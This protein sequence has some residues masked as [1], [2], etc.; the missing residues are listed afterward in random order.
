MRNQIIFKVGMNH[1]LRMTFLQYFDVY[2]TY[3]TR[4]KN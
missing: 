1:K 2:R 4:K 3:W